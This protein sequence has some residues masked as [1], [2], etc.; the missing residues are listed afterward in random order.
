[1]LKFGLVCPLCQRSDHASYCSQYEADE[2]TEVTEIAAVTP[3]H[4]LSLSSAEPVVL[5]CALDDEDEDEYDD[6]CNC[7]GLTF[8]EWL[9]IAPAGLALDV[10]LDAWDDGE[11]PTE[12]CV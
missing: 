9:A 5:D 1:M 3:V 6:D 12:Y 2:V 11:D 8:G 4:T 7:E 10:A